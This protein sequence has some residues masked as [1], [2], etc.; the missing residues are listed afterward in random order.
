MDDVA[1]VVAARSILECFDKQPCGVG[2]GLGDAGVGGLLG[3]G[4]D[5]VDLVLG[6][7]GDGDGGVDFAVVGQCFEDGDDLGFGVGVEVAAGGGAG[8][9][10]AES[11]GAQG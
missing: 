2:V 6:G 1:T 8:V 4:L 7:G 11:V 5:V 3:G 9:G 10:K